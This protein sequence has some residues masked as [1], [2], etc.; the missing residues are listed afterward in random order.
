MDSHFSFYCKPKKGQRIEAVLQVERAQSAA[1]H[2]VLRDS[3]GEPLTEALALL[4]RADENK[5]VPIAQAQSDPEGHF[6]FGGL[7]GDTLYQVKI[8]Q[9]NREIRKLALGEDGTP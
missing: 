8:F 4:F 7:Q 5:D 9:Q 6:A 2:G 3:G 1:I